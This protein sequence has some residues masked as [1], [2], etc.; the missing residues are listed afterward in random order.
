MNSN[1]RLTSTA[2]GERSTIPRIVTAAVGLP[3]LLL[4]VWIGLP[5]FS[6]LVAAAAV[7]AVLELC[8]MARRWG[9]RPVSP[10]AVALSIALIGVSYVYT[11]AS[12]PPAKLLPLASIGAAV[13]L[14]WLLSRPPDTRT[15]STWTA[16]IAAAVYVGG[17]LFHAPVLR[18]ID[19]GREWVL[20]LLLATFAT[21]S[22]AFLVGRTV[23]RRVLA[24][25]IS[26]SKTWEGAIGGILAAAGAAVAGA[27]SWNL[28]IGLGQAAGLGALIGVVG[29]LGDLIESRLKRSA[30]VKDSGWLLPGHGGILD[31]LDSIV[32]NLVVV[33]YFVS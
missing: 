14:V 24:P 12:T 1:T 9:D 18:A 15:S 2:T 7:V 8:G 6:V 28:G 33:Y 3:L 13:S 23:G 19:D 30:D 16:T 11:R 20:F 26:P 21:D 22:F 27:Q 32:L 5:W 25:S 31:R 17:M 10:L 29:Q 4:V